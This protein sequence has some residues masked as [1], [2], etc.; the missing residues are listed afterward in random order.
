MKIVDSVDNVKYYIGND[1]YH[2]HYL[3]IDTGMGYDG[4]KFISNCVLFNCMNDLQ[5]L[6][7]SKNQIDS[8]GFIF[9][10]KSM[11]RGG[12]PQLRVLNLK[13]RYR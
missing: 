7:L 4:I 9:I 12:L 6:D 8:K 5:E 2:F 11:E 10:I 3:W 1:E 13:G